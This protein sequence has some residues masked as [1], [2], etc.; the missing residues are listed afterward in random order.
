MPTFFGPFSPIT[1]VLS[2]VN[3]S[4]DTGLF[5]FSPPLITLDTPSG[6]TSLFAGWKVVFCWLALVNK[7][8][9]SEN[10]LLS[11]FDAF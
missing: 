2:S 9:S 4:E 5:D 1:V 7:S 3:S 8:A 10:L 6:V 11:L